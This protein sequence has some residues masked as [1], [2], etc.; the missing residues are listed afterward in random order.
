VTLSCRRLEV[1]K[2]FT[3]ILKEAYRFPK[4]EESVIK[5]V[6]KEWLKT[7]DLPDYGTPKVITELL[8][9]LVDEPE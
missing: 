2:P 6:V 8:T 3:T 4:N 9:C 7:I 5:E 1:G